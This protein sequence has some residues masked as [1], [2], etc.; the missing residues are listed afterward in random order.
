MHIDYKLV[1]AGACQGGGGRGKSAAGGMSK[2]ELERAF[3]VEGMLVGGGGGRGGGGG[4]GGGGGKR[5]GGA[6]WYGMFRTIYFLFPKCQS[7]RPFTSFF[8][9]KSNPSHG[10]TMNESFGWLD[11]LSTGTRMAA[12]FVC[13]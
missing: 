8:L 4:G 5:G 3:P 10:S 2:A 13:T 11:C 7:P 12:A 9:P 6:Y 1:A